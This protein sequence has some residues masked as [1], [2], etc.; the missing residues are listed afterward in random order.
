MIKKSKFIFKQLHQHFSD[1]DLKHTNEDSQRTGHST[2]VD[3][4]SHSFISEYS[5]K[6]TV[7]KKEAKK[8]EDKVYESDDKANESFRENEASDTKGQ[9]QSRAE[10]SVSILYTFN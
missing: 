1:R 4:K 5:S 10:S 3:A 7:A 2:D 8:T 9:F 6:S